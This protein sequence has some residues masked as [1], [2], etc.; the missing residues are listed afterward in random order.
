MVS[1]IPPEQA[2]HD[3]PVKT[4]SGLAI[5]TVM[6]NLP[7]LVQMALFPFLLSALITAVTITNFGSPLLIIILFILSFI[8]HSLFAVAWHRR[9][10]LN[11]EKSE[12]TFISNWKRV[13]W[14]F[15]LRV[16]QLILIS[17]GLLIRGS[18]P[19]LTLGAAIP[20]SLP[21]LFTVKLWESLGLVGLA[22]KLPDW[23]M[24]LVSIFSI[25]ILSQ[26]QKH[27]NKNSL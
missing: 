9:T 12:P 14:Q 2:V 21:I 1:Q 11:L 26:R 17:Y 18:L 23:Q 8:P 16:I 5:K 20:A 19:A 7:A 22:E 27:W 6:G 24:L 10:L 13:H 3:I 15:L 25:A 4:V